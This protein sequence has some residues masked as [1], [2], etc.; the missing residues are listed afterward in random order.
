VFLT[1][2]LAGVALLAALLV[3]FA[4]L[5]ITAPHRILKAE[6]ESLGERI[7]QL[8]ETPPPG[9]DHSGDVR[10]ALFAVRSELGACATRIVEAQEDERWWDPDSDPL[11]G[12]E[13]AKHFAVLTDIPTQLNADIDITYKSC[14][15]LNHLARWYMEEIKSQ[16]MFLPVKPRPTRLNDH[17]EE[18]LAAA[19]KR[20][21]ETNAAIST[22]LGE[23]SPVV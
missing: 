4:A 21:T 20:I 1:T 10:V 5:W 6:V 2:L 19:L 16:S 18:Q 8:D 13:W 15:R 14:D 3:I 22:H 12:H 7:T 9:T 11:P 17:D 23:G